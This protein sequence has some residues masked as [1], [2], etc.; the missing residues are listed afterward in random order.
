M[1][2]LIKYIVVL[3]LAFN[4]SSDVFAQVSFEPTEDDSKPDTT[5]R[6]AVNSPHPTQV[7]KQIDMIDSYITQVMYI[8]EYFNLRYPG[9]NINADFDE[10]IAL[11]FPELTPE[12]V[13]NRTLFVRKGVQL[14]RWGLKKYA[15]I[16]EKLMV[17]PEPPLIVSDDEYAE[18]DRS[19]YIQADEGQFAIIYDFKKVVTYSPNPRDIDATRAK[20]QKEADAKKNKTNF[21][22]FKSMID[23]I[24]FSKIPYYGYE[25]PNPL[26]GNAGISSWQKVGDFNARLVTELAEYEKASEFLGGVNIVIPNH[27]FILALNLSP[28][29]QKP[30]IELLS[31]ENVESLE[32]FYPVPDKI[33]SESMMAGYSDEILF[34]FKIK[35]QMPNQPIYFKVKFSFESCD[36]RLDCQKIEFIDD[37]E[38]ET[39]E[40]DNYNSFQNFVQ[41][42]YYHLPEMKKNNSVVDNVTVDLAD[43]EKS[44]ENIHITFKYSGV[45]RNPKIFLEDEQATLFATPVISVDHEK[46]YA[47]IRPL[48]NHDKL[49]NQKLKL[50]MQFN[51]ADKLR[52][53]V[54][55]TEK[56]VVKNNF[57]A[58][59]KNILINAFL[60]G[61]LLFL[62][63]IGF[64]IFTVA[65]HQHQAQTSVATYKNVIIGIFSGVF[66][67]TIAALFCQA[68]QIFLF[69]GMQYLSTAYMAA[70]FVII[71][72]VKNM[73]ISPQT[74]SCT[75]TSRK[76]ILLGL[77]LVF[78]APLSFAPFLGKAFIFAYQAS[79]WYLGGF[80]A[81]FATALSIP[82]L[83]AGAIS[84][85]IPEKLKQTGDLWAI[86]LTVV[87]LVVMFLLIL[88]LFSWGQILKIL[89]IIFILYLLIRF[90]FFFE[91]ALQRT[92]LPHSQKS[93][94]EKV[95]LVML[96]GV[97]LIATNFMP[98]F[99]A[100]KSSESSI[101]YALMKEKIEKGQTFIVKVKTDW[102]L[103]CYFMNFI[104]FNK[105]N[106]S[107]WKK[108]Y[109]VDIIEVDA[110]A[111]DQNL[112]DYF[113][114]FHRVAPP[115]YVLYNYQVKDGLVLPSLVTESYVT[116]ALQNLAT[117]I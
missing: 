20:K 89:L 34:P 16:K 42:N 104:T 97:T 105:Y 108:H 75:F 19:P 115:L 9:D 56:T 84:F 51:W 10:D 107:V 43:D 31:S 106:L 91:S 4:I 82:Y 47:S 14:Y 101:P 85:K 12:Q 60:A 54:F 71:L 36:I 8:G 100:P 65:H 39:G 61:L 29:L 24:E 93:G 83:V 63:P 11:M 96:L 50:T 103:P 22:K 90:L 15:E 66:L 23:K 64:L 1:K 116:D 57:Y 95:L 73:M 114:R 67:A 21:D 17:P 53:D 38:I 88:S 55:L 2:N 58:E 32:L 74:F 59:I 45:I 70:V 92:D 86:F 27:R 33:L 77:A 109:K 5:I 52:Q 112:A 111:M 49:L 41:Q 110:T 44:V 99:I 25:L 35:T 28:E 13:R 72:A 6:Q 78:A 7:R 98:H 26:V 69:W 18:I 76:G 62:M 117:G 48:T 68:H 3:F 87:Q 113:Y 81:V 37:L 79:P 102:C 46:V 40:Y 80:A 94:T 30:K